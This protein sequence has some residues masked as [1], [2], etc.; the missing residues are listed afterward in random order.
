MKKIITTAILIT[1][2]S[3]TTIFGQ[4]HTSHNVLEKNTKSV[5]LTTSTDET[6]EE[7][8]H[9]LVNNES[10]ITETMYDGLF[11]ES[12]E[13][14]GHYYS[15]YDIGKKI[16]LESTINQLVEHTANQFNDIT[17]SEWF[18][19]EVALGATL[20]ITYGYTD[21]TFRP[22]SEVTRL[23]FLSML[24]RSALGQGNMT[25]QLQNW[26]DGIDD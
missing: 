26:Q 11:A 4:T 14:D 18:A 9:I 5:N 22:N 12:Y 23:E 3:S 17:G 6:K 10:Q 1:I 8:K 20:G 19:K 13:R 15:G 16:Q 21:G 25:K 7:Y 24:G 2:I